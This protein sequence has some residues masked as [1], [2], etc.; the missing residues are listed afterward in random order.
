MPDVAAPQLTDEQTRAL[1]VVRKVAQLK[2][3]EGYWFYQPQDYQRS[4]AECLAHRVVIHGGNR[5]G[6]TQHAIK[7][8]LDIMSG[9]DPL[10]KLMGWDPPIYWRWNGAGM[11][12]Q[13][14]KVLVEWFRK[15]TPR[16]WC[17]NGEFNVSQ[18]ANRLVFAERGP[19]RG[20]W[21]EFMSYDQDPES[22]SGRPLHGTGF[23][24]AYKCSRR[25]RNQSLSRL[26]DY[27]GVAWSI[28]TPEEGD[29]TWSVEWYERAKDGD[30]DYAAFRYP[31]RENKF[32]YPGYDKTQVSPAI[33]QIVKDCDGDEIQLRIRLDGDFISIGGVVYPMLKPEFH[34]KHPHEFHVDSSWTKYV[35]ID[36]GVR[37][38]H[39]VT[40]HLVGPGKRCY[41]YRQAYI[42]GTMED[43]CVEIRKLSG[44]EQFAAFNFDPHWD[45]NNN[46]AKMKDGTTPFNLQSSLREAMNLAGYSEVPLMPARKDSSMWFGIDQVASMLQVDGPTGMP[47]LAFS[48]ECMELYD[49][50]RRYSCVRSKE[51]DPSAHRPRIRKID[52]DGPDCVRIAVTSPMEYLA[53]VGGGVVIREEIE[54]EFGVSW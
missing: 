42:V 25:F 35:D 15:L 4:F 46:T 51:R 36:P 38:A 26:L 32:L 40:W 21:C 31:T 27:H 43:M 8:T 48:P 54:D 44:K 2:R 16:A 34:V 5:A 11:E 39:R 52:D 14:R 3:T 49:E 24:E 33:E 19:C 17:E 13:V 47:N 9:V 45:W 50:M 18:K 1:L 12:E 30:P 53:H 28:E 10:N 22:G 37:K 6:K 20:G 23:D 41:F 29:A 7:R